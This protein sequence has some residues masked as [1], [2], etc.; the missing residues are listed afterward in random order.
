MYACTST[1]QNKN[2]NT[3]AHTEK[4][5]HKC[6]H[7][8]GSPNTS[9][10][11]HACSKSSGDRSCNQEQKNNNPI[12]MMPPC[13]MPKKLAKSYKWSVQLEDNLMYLISQM[14]WRVGGRGKLQLTQ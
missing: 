2:T 9:M 5:M 8:I 12:S 4:H 7:F 6:T 11:S 14:G 3:Q 10:S 13:K 1:Q